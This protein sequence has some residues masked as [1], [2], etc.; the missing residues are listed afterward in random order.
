MKNIPVRYPS[1]KWQR[2]LVPLFYF[3]W[4]KRLFYEHPHDP[5]HHYISRVY[6]VKG[7]RTALVDQLGSGRITVTFL[8]GKGK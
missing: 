4:W 8:F 7:W 5:D 6:K 3:V 1:G 2:L